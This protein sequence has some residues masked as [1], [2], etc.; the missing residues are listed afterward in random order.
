VTLKAEIA[1]LRPK[2]GDPCLLKTSLILI[3]LF[4][5]F[6]PVLSD[7]VVTWSNDGDYSHGFFVLPAVFYLV[8][9]KR[10][11]LAAIQ[12]RTFWPAFPPLVISTALYVVSY[13]VRFH[14]LTS[15][16]IV[17]TIFFLLLFLTGWRMSKALIFPT[18]FLFFLFPL[19]NGFYVLITNPLK[20]FI[21]AV[22]AN[23]I[24]AL[25]IP[26]YREGNLLFFPNTQLEVA[27]ACSGIRSLISYLMLGSLFAYF[28]SGWMARVILF[29]SALPLSLFVNFLRVV[30]TGILAFSF[31]PQVS[32]GFF[33]EFSGMVLFLIGLGV[34]LLEYLFFSN[35]SSRT[36][37]T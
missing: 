35:R 7:L 25:G 5:L 10:H 15:F 14:S 18:L 28:S 20:L 33:H 22:S 11:D 37:T 31:G 17:S 8:W 19:P 9:G 27:E 13:T 34:L 26:V 30:I 12:T 24:S 29:G 23:A 6:A 4:V 36:K 3:L 32:R 21:T 1:D 16:A 2:F